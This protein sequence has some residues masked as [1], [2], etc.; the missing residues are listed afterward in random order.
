MCEISCRV[1]SLKI[2][3]LPISSKSLPTASLIACKLNLL[4]AWRLGRFVF[5]GASKLHTSLLQ[6]AFGPA[7]ADMLPE[8]RA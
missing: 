7:A 2:P 3:S 1:Y 8:N 4:N 5:Y 6:L